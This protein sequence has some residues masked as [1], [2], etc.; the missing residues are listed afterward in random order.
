MD[1]YNALSRVQLI[2]SPQLGHSLGWTCSVYLTGGRGGLSPR[3]HYCVELYYYAVIPLLDLLYMT[4]LRFY[5]R[6][7]IIICTSHI[8]YDE[9]AR[10]RLLSKWMR[11]RIQGRSI[12]ALLVNSLRLSVQVYDV[13]PIFVSLERLASR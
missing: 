5:S 1:P 3:T 4:I 6:I 12:G 10:T 2:S 7:S 13:R 8:M 9:H 11:G